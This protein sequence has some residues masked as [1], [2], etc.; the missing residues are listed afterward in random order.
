ML[1]CMY[2]GEVYN[3]DNIVFDKYNE[4]NQCPKANCDGYIVD[5]DEEILPHIMLLNNKGYATQYC[6]QGHLNN[7]VARLY[8]LFENI[9]YFDD[10]PKG[11]IEEDPTGNRTCI[12][13]EPK[14]KNN[15][16]KY[17]EL[18][19]AR[20]N[21]YDWIYKLDDINCCF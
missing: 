5:I 11:F 15:K 17:K 3:K 18:L 19:K 16:Q 10:L 4:W 8:I 1:V 20:I 12:S 6:C 9:Y 14:S 2:C 7:S 21:L 13:F